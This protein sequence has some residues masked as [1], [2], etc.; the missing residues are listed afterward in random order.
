MARHL[1]SADAASA[2]RRFA[3]ARAAASD[4]AQHA[5]PGVAARLGMRDVQAV[6][7]ALA[8]EAVNYRLG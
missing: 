2:H 3:H 8:G 1:A 5:A 7:E 4:F 6:R